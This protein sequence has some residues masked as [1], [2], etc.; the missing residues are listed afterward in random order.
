MVYVV[1]EKVHGGRTIETD[2]DLTDL[3][4]PDNN[5][6]NKEFFMAFAGILDL[7]LDKKLGG[8]DYRVFLYLCSVM[9][10]GGWIEETQ[11]AIAKDMKTYQ[12]N[13]S[14]S[15][16]RLKEH[17]YVTMERNQ[18]GRLK[19]RI[20]PEIAGR[21]SFAKVNARK[22]LARKLKLKDG[23]IKPVKKEPKE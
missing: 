18:S 8:T 1:T 23:E 7:V 10:D 20:L 14:E 16:T 13:V 5:K 6:K 2:N 9:T 11:A 3:W 17:G 19:L 4:L 21:G 15:I 22:A 12:A